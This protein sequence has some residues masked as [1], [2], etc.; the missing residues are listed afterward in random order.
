MKLPIGCHRGRS[1]IV[2]GAILSL[3]LSGARTASA[4]TTFHLLNNT[5]ESQVVTLSLDGSNYGGYYAGR[6]WG[7]LDNGPAFRTFCVDAKH[8]IGFDDTYL[9]DPTHSLTDPA[10]PVVGSY[11]NGG[12][13]SALVNGDIAN[14]SSS[15]A[16]ERA[17]MAGWLVNRYLNATAATFSG[18]FTGSS[19]LLMNLAALQIS[20]WDIIDDGANG[21]AAGTVLGDG[22]TQASYGGLVSYF[23]TQAAAHSNEASPYVKFIQAP[24]SGPNLDHAQDFTTQITPEG[25]SLLMLLAALA[26]PGIGILLHRKRQSVQ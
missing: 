5:S 11:Y 24:I 25:N 26:V 20:L 8:H 15:S 17:N 21:L 6:Y 7:T 22:T 10:G 4:Q 14:V 1:A 18:G 9:S 3:A 19:S 23:E 16:A 2:L 13:A 12:L